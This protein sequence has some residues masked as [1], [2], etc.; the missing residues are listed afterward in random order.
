MM[1]YYC[2]GNHL[3]FPSQPAKARED[4]QFFHQN[5]VSRHILGNLRKIIIIF[6]FI[7]NYLPKYDS[8]EGDVSMNGCE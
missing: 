6:I 5:L 1:L 3:N 8:N 7:N 2:V 4:I